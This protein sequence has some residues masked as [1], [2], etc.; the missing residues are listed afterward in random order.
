MIYTRILVL[1]VLAA[2]AACQPKGAAPATTTSSGAMSAAGSS[3]P[4]ASTDNSAPVAIVNGSPI[5]RDFFDFYAKG[6]SG[7]NSLADL[8][9]EQKQQALDTLIRA[10]VI[11]Q[12]ATK[13]GLDKDPSTA[14][15]LQL[16]RLNVLQQAVSDRYLKDKKPTEQEARAEYETEVGLLAHQEY[17]V[18]HILVAT[19]GFARKLIAEIEKGANFTDVAKRESMDPSKTNG[20]DI[21]WLTP[22]RIMKP[23]ADAMVALKKGEYTH[24]PVQTQYGW[25]IIRVDDIR[26]VTPPTFDQVHQRLDQVV[27]NKKFKA[28]SDGLMKNAQIEKKL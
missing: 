9:P 26:D 25:H 13:E 2:L 21:G 10:Q 22:D 28:Y 24:K 15:L 19:E 7:K 5:N 4:P 20:G 1:C 6:V 23:F 16:A 18:N 14:A 11:A 12:E 17:H 27:Q 3:A 8:T